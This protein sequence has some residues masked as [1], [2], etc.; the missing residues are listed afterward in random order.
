MASADLVGVDEILAS[1]DRAQEALAGDSR[2]SRRSAEAVLDES[3]RRAPRG[4]TSRLAG[5]GRV[6]GS[7]DGYDVVYAGEL[8]FVAQHFGSGPGRPQG[9]SNPAVPFLY[10]A[11]DA[12]GGELQRIADDE[13]VDVLRDVGLM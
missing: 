1:I 12:V 10:A 9:G 3:A 7:G 6:I 11:P 4:E 8:Y 5:A 13:T 2:M